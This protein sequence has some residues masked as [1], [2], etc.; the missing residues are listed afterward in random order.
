MSAREWHLRV[1]WARAVSNTIALASMQAR[2]SVCKRVHGGS[3][4]PCMPV[5]ETTRHVWLATPSHL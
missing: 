2:A 1:R 5:L 4:V 3:P